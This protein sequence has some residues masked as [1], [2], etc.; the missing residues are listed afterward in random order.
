[1]KEFVGAAVEAARE[2]GE[3]L[4]A[5]FGQRHQVERKGPIDYVTEV[6]REAEEVLRRYLGGRFPHHAILGEEGGAGG[7]ADAEYRWIIDPVD[8][9]TNFV[10]GL[11]RFCV[12]VALERAGEVV[13]GVIYAPLLD[14]L[15]I[16]E[17]G[18][19][20]YLLKDAPRGNLAGGAHRLSV[21]TQDCLLGALLATGF[22]YDPRE[23]ATNLQEVEAVLRQV[24]D[25]RRLGSAALDLADVA[26]GRLDGYFEGAVHAWDI[27]AGALLVEEAGGRV[28]GLSGGP[29]RFEERYL[30]CTNGRLHDELLLALKEALATQ[31][32]VA[33]GPKREKGGR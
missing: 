5:G 9:T 1:M 8:G 3:V 27:A 23:W 30:V 10:H 25:I 14:E 31:A 19:G 26:R 22:P 4:A 24:R 6:D 16:A 20:A 2:A 12:S 17:R 28:T 7:A 32:P 33:G 15:Y 21:S 18:G 13:V 11:E 29:L